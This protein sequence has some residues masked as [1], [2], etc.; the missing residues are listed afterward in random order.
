[1]STVNEARRKNK[2]HPAKGCVKFQKTEHAASALA[3]GNYTWAD[4]QRTGGNVI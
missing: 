3:E 4:V 1:M 2:T